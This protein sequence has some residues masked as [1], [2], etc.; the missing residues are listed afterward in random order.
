MKKE[1]K[2][3]LVQIE[4]IIEN[5]GTI[6]RQFV[7]DKSGI[8]AIIKFIEDLEG[9][10]PFFE[11]DDPVVQKGKTA[12]ERVIESLEEQMKTL[13]ALSPPPSWKKFHESFLESIKLQLKGYK[14]MALVFED[15]NVDH[16]IKGQELIDKGMELLE[17]GR[18]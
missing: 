2:T 3:Y 8:R 5:F 16:I 9:H 18:K 10:R 12:A 11:L 15:S 14:E 17:G 6:Q 1:E 13:E 7:L 4:K